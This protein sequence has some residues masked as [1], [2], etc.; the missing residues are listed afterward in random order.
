MALRRQG[1]H[2]Y[3]DSPSD[4]CA[5]LLVYSRKNG[6]PVEH[7]ADAACGCGGSH[8]SLL[9]DDTEGAAVR[10]CSA[11]SSRHPMGDSEEY[12]ADASLMECECPC[13]SGSF[14]ITVGVA[15]H[16]GSRDV[17]WIYIGARCVG[18]GLTACYGDWKNEFEDYE[19]LLK[20]I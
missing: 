5:R 11:C 4:I 7:F 3:G 8:F 16:S 14:E 18:C 19:L 1:H 17:R 15:L 12:L 20:R 6:Y 9:L 2:Y 10:I 13:G